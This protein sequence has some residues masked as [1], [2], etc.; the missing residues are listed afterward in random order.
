[1]NLQEQISRIQEMM[2]VINENPD[3]VTLLP[4]DNFRRPNGSIGTQGFT[5]ESLINLIKHISRVQEFDLPKFESVKDLIFSLREDPEVIDKIVD[6]V[7][8]DPVIILKLP[9][10]TYVIKDGN[11]RANLLNLLN[12]DSV[13]TIVHQ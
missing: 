13:P 1:M 3:E 5:T 10:D 4:L 7:K 8:N 12:V 9:D 6:Y 2:G 11:H